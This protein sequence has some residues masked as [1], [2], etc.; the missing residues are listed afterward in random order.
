MRM[1]KDEESNNN[2]SYWSNLWGKQKDNQTSG[3][4]VL[5]TINEHYHPNFSPVFLCSLTANSLYV[6]SSAYNYIFI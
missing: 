4:W 2:E 1:M 3:K 6:L 5:V